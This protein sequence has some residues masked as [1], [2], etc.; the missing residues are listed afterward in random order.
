MNLDE[1]IADVVKGM[2]P[3]ADQLGLDGCTPGESG[4]GA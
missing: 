4:S 1:L 3:V 2:K